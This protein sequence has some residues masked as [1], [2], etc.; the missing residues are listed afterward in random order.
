MYYTYKSSTPSHMIQNFHKLAIKD[1]NGPKLRCNV[2]LPSIK[3]YEPEILLP[4]IQHIKNYSK[5]AISLSDITNTSLSKSRIHLSQTDYEEMED[6][7]LNKIDNRLRDST[8]ASAGHLDNL[9]SESI[10]NTDFSTSHKVITRD[11]LKQ[12]WEESCSEA[13]NLG[14]EATK[15]LEKHLILFRQYCNGRKREMLPTTKGNSQVN[16]PM[17]QGQ[18]TGRA[19]RVFNTHHI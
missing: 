10:M 13:D 12:L 8:C 9:F 1:I 11:A 4:A 5:S 7:I 17:T 15:E 2:N 16:I 3:L 14:V 6:D 19:D 18:Y